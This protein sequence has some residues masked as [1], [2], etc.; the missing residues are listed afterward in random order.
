MMNNPKI[1]DYV[2]FVCRWS[3]MPKLG[4]VTKLK[5]NPENELFSYK[6]PYAEVDWYNGENSKNPGLRCGSTTVLLKSLYK[7]KQELFAAIRKEVEKKSEK[8][9]S[10]NLILS[11]PKC[12][13][14]TFKLKSDEGVFHAGLSYLTD[15]MYD[16]LKMCLTYLQTGAAAVT[17]DRESEGTFL[18]VVSDCD[19]YVLDENLESGMFHFENLKATDICQNILDSY[20]SCPVAWI[21][22]ANMEG[23]DEANYKKYED[24]EAKEIHEM[25][26][27]IR[28][29]LNEK[30]GI[31]SKWTEIRCDF[32]DEE[33]QAWLVDAWKTG[34]D[35]EEGEVIAKISE[36]REV[37]YLDVEAEDDEYAKEVIDEKLKDLA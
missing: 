20:Y 24:A 2:W 28:R 37:V 14:C 29:L 7:T 5:V 19:V 9:A 35:N 6:E 10:K 16:T 32:F 31:K 21:N 8:I 27:E 22:F 11:N 12:G 23:Q 34:D 4:V 30:T 13:W 33:E 15:V 18:F 3:D 26:K 17:Y 1:G 25:I 36:A